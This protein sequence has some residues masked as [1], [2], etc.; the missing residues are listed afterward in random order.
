MKS[1]KNLK[2]LEDY[3][4]YLPLLIKQLHDKSDIP[5]REDCP[6][7]KNQ[8]PSDP[9]KTV[10]QNMQN[11]YKDSDSINA[12]LS[13]SELNHISINLVPYLLNKSLVG[14]TITHYKILE[15][16][17]IGGMGVVYKAKDLILERFVTIKFL[18]PHLLVDDAAKKRFIHEARSLSAL[19]H[20]NICSIYEICETPEGF[21]FI[22]MPYYQGKTLRSKI[23]EG[24]ARGNLPLSIG[25]CID[26]IMQIAQGLTKAHEKGVVHRDIKPDNI[27]ITEDN[28]V[29]I[30]DFGLS[31]LS[32]STKL[33]EIGTTMGTVYYMSPEQSWGTEVDHRTDIWSLG[34]VFYEMLAR[35]LPFRGGYEQAVIYSIVNEE[36]EEIK[37]IPP[38]LKKVINKCLAKKADQ[39]YNAMQEFIEDIQDYQNTYLNYSDQYVSLGIKKLKRKWAILVIFIM[40][41]LPSLIDWF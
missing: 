19:D 26:I 30:I 21:L 5:T 20:P 33:S 41:V 31:K 23:D 11:D 34:V 36:P 22:V 15:K 2:T 12:A 17:G 1:I 16:I 7:D 40:I 6:I 18:P 3:Q 4:N 13:S 32:E 8:P 37:H 35:K 24:G 9:Q 27:I 10:E 14:E 25:D 28:V 39:R 29:K 38:K